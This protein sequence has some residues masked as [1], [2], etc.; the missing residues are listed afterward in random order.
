MIFAIEFKDKAKT[1]VLKHQKSG[2]KI[3]VKRIK[4]FVI[5]CHNEPRS[6]TGKPE[7][8][9]FRNQETWSRRINNKH[10]FVYEIDETQKL[11]YIL[12]A[13]GH[14]EGG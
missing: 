3:L 11:V 9:K 12:S 4:N 5:E 13:W 6:G 7:Q 14:Y 10:R 1:D 8:L 2:N